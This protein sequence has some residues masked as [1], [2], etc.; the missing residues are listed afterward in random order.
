VT[1]WTVRRLWNVAVLRERG[2]M[3][4]LV[5]FLRGILFLLL[6]GFAVKN[7]K[8][9]VLSYFFGYEWET[10]L[11]LLLL[12]FFTAGVIAGVLV[13]LFTLLRQRREL[14]QLRNEL[15]KKEDAGQSKEV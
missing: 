9:V 1:L 7:D 15:R 10:S 11:V 2:G 6:L 14:S 12:L 5:W 3:K 8:P 4:Y 13:M